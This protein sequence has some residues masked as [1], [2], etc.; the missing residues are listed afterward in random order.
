MPATR[1]RRRQPQRPLI[2]PPP[3]V[4]LTPPRT[5]VAREHE[6]G[7]IPTP[8]GTGE[9]EPPREAS[10]ALPQRGSVICVQI[11]NA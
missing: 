5:L 7:I 3:H 1:R 4:P 10:I 2:A 8:R 9:D 6:N 11:W